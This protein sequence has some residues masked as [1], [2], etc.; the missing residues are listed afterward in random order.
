MRNTSLALLML[1]VG[2]ERAWAEEENP[3][4]VQVV[5]RRQFQLK[6][7]L[8]L[9]AGFLPLDAFYKGLTANVG[10]T[11]HFNPH[12]AWRVG[13]GT[14]SQPFSTGLRK[15]IQSLYGLEVTDFPE[16]HWMVGSDLVWNAFYGKTAFM[17]STLLHG[18]IYLVAGGDLVLTQVSAGPGVALGGGLRLFVTEWLSFRL[19][20]LDHVVIAKTPFNVVD[21]QLAVAVNLGA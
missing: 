7:E 2:S 11:Y 14:F 6:H 9:S 20:V 18:S 21:L 5:Q 13:R 12:F 16:V 8:T 19:E 4:A 15:Q 10:Y 1:L 17:N 3:A